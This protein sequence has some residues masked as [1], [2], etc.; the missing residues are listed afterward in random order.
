M[1]VDSVAKVIGAGI[2]MEEE[3]LKVY[4][5]AAA[6]TRHPFAKEMFLSLAHDETR[7]AEWFRKMAA[8]RGVAPAPLS[9]LDPDGFLKTISET[10]KALRAQ[11]KSLKASADDI[12]AIDV[13]LG[14]EE[15]SY[16]V[17]TE[18]AAKATNPDEKAVLQFIAREENNHWKI[19][20]DT[21]LY[22]TDWEKWNIKDEKPVIDGGG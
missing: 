3:G 21:R 10:F 7:H 4:Q 11:I 9:D 14:L 6:R 17:Y 8:Q 19:L 22:L 12:K 13:A 16:K 20:D 18:A 5:E 15:K 2:R 1:A